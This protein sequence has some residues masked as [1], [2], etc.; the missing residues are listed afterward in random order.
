MNL[1][2]ECSTKD[3]KMIIDHNDFMKDASVCKEIQDD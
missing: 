3:N 1:C 2:L